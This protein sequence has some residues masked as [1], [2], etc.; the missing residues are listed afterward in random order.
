MD[1]REVLEQCSK[2]A[3]AGEDLPQLWPISVQHVPDGVTV[4][5]GSGI[6]AV[7]MDYQSCNITVEPGSGALLF[8]FFSGTP[9]FM[10]NINVNGTYSSR[11]IATDRDKL[12]IAAVADTGLTT[13]A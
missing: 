6:Y 10:A 1:I 9:P 2:A 5:R 13:F 4:L 8:L 3:L 12:V 11:A 7:S